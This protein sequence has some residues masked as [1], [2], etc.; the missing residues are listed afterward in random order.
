MENTQN[1]GE[2]T[3]VVASDNCIS[4]AVDGETVIL[5]QKNG[6]YYSVN[7]VGTLVWELIQRPTTLDE[8]SKE[9]ASEY[10]VGRERCQRDVSDMLAEMLD[11][12]LVYLDE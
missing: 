3:T 1:I 2:T 4:T 6:E 9:I 12:N 8:V 10:G 7:E 5:H 11:E